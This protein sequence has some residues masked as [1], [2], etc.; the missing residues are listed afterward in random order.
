MRRLILF[1]LILFIWYPV[2]AQTETW[3]A[4]TYDDLNGEMIQLDSTG[5]TRKSVILPTIS[6]YTYP[7]NVAV[8]PQGD[9]VG[10]TLSGNT[11]DLIF[12]VFDLVSNVNLMSY[13]VPL[14]GAS[15][16]LTYA[17]PSE[18][19]SQDGSQVAFAYATPTEWT[20]L[21]LDMSGQIIQQTSRANTSEI[22]VPMWFDGNIV[23][24]VMMPLAAG[25]F[26]SLSSAQWD[27]TTNTLQPTDRFPTIMADLEPRTGEIIY[28]MLDTQFRDRSAD[29][30][31]MGFHQNS[32]QVALPNSVPF[33]FYVDENNNIDSAYFIQNGERILLQVTQIDGDSY[34]A[35]TIIERDGVY[36]GL[37]P[38]E[39]LWID[40]I[41]GVGDGFI[42]SAATTEL[43]RFFPTLRGVNSTAVVYVPTT[44]QIQGNIGQVIFT[45]ISGTTAR[46]VWA[47]D[48]VNRPLPNTAAWRPVGIV[49]PN[50]PSNNVS[51]GMSDQLMI[52]GMARV[53]L[54]GDGLNLRTSPSINAPAVT[55]LNALDILNVIGGPQTADGFVWWQVSD[56]NVSGWAAGG[57][58]SELWLEVYTGGTLPPPMTS[59]DY[60]ALTSPQ[61]GDAIYAFQVSFNGQ[62]LPLL[63]QWQAVPNALEYVLEFEQC[64]ATT[65]TCTPI[66]A[67][68]TPLTEYSVNLF[69]FGYGLYR[70][71]VVVTGGGASEWRYFTF[72]Q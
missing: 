8:A 31:G 7:Y 10:Y 46:L 35:L 57:D 20:L 41:I 52:G 47:Q 29:M 12:T 44:T 53:T 37:L 59:T 2:K 40:K 39:N 54:E 34:G 26:A 11:G 6:G 66:M 68:Y 70:W 60:P 16:S 22:P 71:R 17:A 51:V 55:Q 64:D 27:I 63:F 4:W 28:P 14:S 36:A 32:V 13:R 25:G 61:D 67:F 3:F 5:F 9:R 58:L 45:G 1:I 24:V 43:E 72:E 56:G 23:H 62:P 30:F 49:S 33:P 38:Y 42:F 50:P 15:D 69:D 18:I 65:G 19:F 48:L 21:V